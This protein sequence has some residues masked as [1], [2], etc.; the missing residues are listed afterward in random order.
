MP[1]DLSTLESSV[2]ALAEQQ[3]FAVHWQIRTLAH[4]VG[5]RS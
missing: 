1:A 4:R 3:P 5:S 2:S